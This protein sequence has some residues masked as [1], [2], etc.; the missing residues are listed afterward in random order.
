[1]IDA[2]ALAHHPLGVGIRQQS[3]A[4][5]QHFAEFIEIERL[6]SFYLTFELDDTRGV[7][8]YICEILGTHTVLSGYQFDKPYPRSRI[9]VGYIPQCIINSLHYGSL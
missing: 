9:W 8:L 2:V 4:L 3:L 6:A 1:M 5:K 7:N